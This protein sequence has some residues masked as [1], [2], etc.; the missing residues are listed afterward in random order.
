MPTKASG[1]R[2]SRRFRK[3][4]A[5]R[6]RPSDLTLGRTSSLAER[7]QAQR[8]QLFKAISIVE[9]C[10]YASA[11]KFAV[12]DLEYMAF[13][14]DAINDLLNSTAGEL[15]GIASCVGSED[16]AQDADDADVDR[17]ECR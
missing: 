14:F 10:K 8:R 16:P 13:A 7:L 15:E 5:T 17:P 3:S 9:C 2:G 11:T 6:E 1:A 12:D 4:R